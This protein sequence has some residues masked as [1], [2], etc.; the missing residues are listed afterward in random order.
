VSGLPVIVAERARAFAIGASAVSGSPVR[1]PQASVPSGWMRI[2]VDSDAFK[3]TFTIESERFGRYLE[4]ILAKLAEADEPALPAKPKA[5]PR[6]RRAKPVEK[7]RT[8]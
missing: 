5:A 7:K 2:R 1:R 8:K 3:G 4:P 6:A